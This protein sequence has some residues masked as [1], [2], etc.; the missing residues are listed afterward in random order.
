M[1]PEYNCMIILFHFIDHVL[2]TNFTV[3][4]KYRSD[5]STVPTNVL[6]ILTYFFTLFLPYPHKVQKSL[7]NYKILHPLRTLK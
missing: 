5:M 2:R 6:L 4:E 7:L 3:I 1:L